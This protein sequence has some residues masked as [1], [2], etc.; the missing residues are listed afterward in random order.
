MAKKGH[1]TEMPDS[2]ADAHAGA[3]ITSTDMDETAAYLARGRHLAKTN[4]ATLDSAWLAGFQALVD[5]QPEGLL[6]FKDTSAEIRLRGRA[7]PDVPG[8][9]MERLRRLIKREGPD[10]PGVIAAI[11]RYFERLDN[12]DA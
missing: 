10:N 7:Y 9:L 2:L 4:D 8:E 12:P 11:D 6:G 5:E 1:S 3:L